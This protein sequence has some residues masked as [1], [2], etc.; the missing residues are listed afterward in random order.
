MTLFADT[1]TYSETPITAGT[2]RYAA[3][4]EVML[5]PYAIDDGPVR[6]WDRTEHPDC[7][8]DLAIAL[9]EDADDEVVFHNAMFD[10]AVLRFDLPAL[11]P[12]LPR[13]RCS[14]VRAMAHGLPG[15]LEKLGE[16]FGLSEDQAKLKDGRELIHL[17]CK[18]RPKTSKLRRATRLTHPQEW[19][20]FKQYAANDIT[21]MREIWHKLPSWNYRGEELALWHLDQRI[22]DRGVQMD[23]DLARAAIEATEREKQR[24][25]DRTFD[26]TEGRVG[27]ATQRDALLAYIL[28]AHDIELPDLQTSTIE[29]LLDKDPDLPAPVRELLAVRVA[30]TKASTSKYKRVAQGVNVDGRL[31]GLL[32]FAGAMRTARWAGRLFQPQNLPRPT[33]EQPEIETAIDAIK[34]GLGDL[35]LADDLMQAASN[36]LR[37]LIVAPK[38]RKLVVADL[39]NI[40]GRDQAWLAGEAWKLDAFRA[41]DAGQGPDL[42]KLAYS[43]SFGIKP[44]EVTKPQ[45][46]IGKVQELAL[47]YEGGVGAFVTMAAGYGMDLEAMAR[48]AWDIL[49][50][51]L[52]A[53]AVDFHEW[54]RSKNAPAVRALPFE[55]FVTCDVFKRGWRRGHA[56][57]AS[58]WKE[59]E[60]A[61]IAA[62]A[63]PGET[64]R[65]RKLAVRRD[66]AWLRI[67]LPSGRALCYPRPEILD[68]GKLA[69]R[70][71]NQYSRKWC[72]LRT[73]GGKLF[74]NVCQA[75]ARDVMAAAMPAIEAAGYRIVLTVHDEVI[76]EA[77]DVPEFN[78]PHLAGLLAGG[79]PWT[80]G[81]P[82]AAAGFECYR[83][84]KD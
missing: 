50:A 39:S 6:V 76:C 29:K 79:A 64:I 45:R 62:T 59:L 70:G 42:Y 32:Q 36:A 83:Y 4:A 56:Q 73:Y 65:A 52:K 15:S 14:M 21:A 63:N 69:Y 77:P 53:E 60:A 10:R 75:A 35:L 78:A 8:L 11:C 23:V 61:A 58:Y 57:I 34:C 19:A 3:D 1:E 81:L 16:L 71:I 68:D 54:Q 38:G 25:A 33:M 40:E 55:V 13:W 48:Q 22:N 80:R 44:E 28:A 49:P 27:K 74:E 26:L 17:F 7:P 30:A 31:R 37:G 2:F 24:L 9:L 18:P 67:V 12:P 66:G 51:D 43:K 46:Q 72:R 20:R 84:R 82:L 41:F 5:F 47:G